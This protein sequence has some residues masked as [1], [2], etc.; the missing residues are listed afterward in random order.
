MESSKIEDVS[1]ICTCRFLPEA[2]ME[3]AGTGGEVH[4]IFKCALKS[5]KYLE[6]V[7]VI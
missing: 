5:I 2:G 4:K 1:S 3:T 6:I 7:F